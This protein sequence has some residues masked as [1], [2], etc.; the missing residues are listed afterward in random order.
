MGP[1]RQI[2]LP[3]FPLL[4]TRGRT[5]LARHRRAGTGCQIEDIHLA[6]VWYLLT[7]RATRGVAIYVQLL[8]IDGRP[9]VRLSACPQ[10]GWPSMQVY[11]GPS[12]SRGFRSV[13][14]HWYIPRG[15]PLTRGKHVT[16][17]VQGV[18]RFSLP[19]FVTICTI[20]SSWQGS[21]MCKVEKGTSRVSRIAT[22]GPSTH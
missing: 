1:C 18:G 9:T 6:G 4:D 16:L 12:I 19:P 10:K 20:S 14:V 7:A 2:W 22:S 11:A 5:S 13:F 15:E 3:F 17:Q 21:R 8:A